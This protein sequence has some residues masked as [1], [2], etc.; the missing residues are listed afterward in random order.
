MLY[1][2]WIKFLLMEN[3]NEQMVGFEILILSEK[4]QTMLWPDAGSIGLAAAQKTFLSCRA[5]RRRFQLR[6]CSLARSTYLHLVVVLVAVK[7]AAP[8]VTQN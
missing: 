2:E 5:P 4:F 1:V 7:P 6:S 8:Q 3:G